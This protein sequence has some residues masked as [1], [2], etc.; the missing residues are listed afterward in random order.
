MEMSPPIPTV[1]SAEILEIREGRI[2]RGDNIYDAEPAAIVHWLSAGPR[3]AA[4]RPVSS[5]ALQ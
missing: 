1:T 4:G 2:V 3:M 5:V